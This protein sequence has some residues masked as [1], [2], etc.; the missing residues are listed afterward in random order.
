VIFGIAKQKEWKMFRFEELEIWEM[1]CDVGHD[2]CD[3]ADSLEKKR[4]Y[5]F[6]EQLRSA[7]LSISNIN[8]SVRDS[9]FPQLDLLSRK[10][11]SFSRTL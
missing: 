3:I 8:T 5:R 7:A 9:A 4:L 10:I 11:T 1:A 6:A 2:L